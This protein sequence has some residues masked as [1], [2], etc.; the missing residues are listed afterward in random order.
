MQDSGPVGPV[1]GSKM[2]GRPSSAPCDAGEG[3]HANLGRQRALRSGRKGGSEDKWV[4]DIAQNA[5]TPNSTSWREV[6][7]DANVWACEVGPD[8]R[9]SVVSGMRSA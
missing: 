1:G 5:M 9:K 7:E 6:I 3:Q 8:S 4:Y 2:V